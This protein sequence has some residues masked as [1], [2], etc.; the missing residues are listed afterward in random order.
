MTNELDSHSDASPSNDQAMPRLD[1]EAVLG[2]VLAGSAEPDTVMRLIGEL[3]AAGESVPSEIEH[4]SLVHYISEDPSRLDLKKRLVTV[5]K[6]LGKDIPDELANEVRMSY[7]EEERGTDFQAMM[8]EY[9]ARVGTKDMRPEFLKDYAE[10]RR[11]SMTSVERLYALWEAIDYLVENDIAGDIVECGVWRGGS[12]M[13]AAKRLTQRSCQSK[14]LWLYDTFTGLPKPDTQVD[15][16]ILGNRAID[17]WEPR[18]T[19][20]G[21]TYWGYA[22]EEDVRSNMLSTGYPEENLRF[23]RGMVE[24]T[25]PGQ[26]PDKISLLRI[27]TDWY[28]SY[29]HVLENL[30]ERVSIGGIIIFDDYGQFLGA[31]KAVDEY[32]SKHGVRSF[33]HRVD[34][35][36]RIMIRDH[37]PQP[38]DLESA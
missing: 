27:D 24:D 7:I 6:A 3:L 38:G 9:G 18:N 16:D 32:R 36:C 30:F 11:H 4:Y 25:I 12:M 29:R 13:L 15:V 2:Q 33:M 28:A 37:H 34:F 10:I 22:T 8:A 31:R 14:R 1:K 19:C 20:E 5:L 21:E 26:A 23:V 17:G 35:S